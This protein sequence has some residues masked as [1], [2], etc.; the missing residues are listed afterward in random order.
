MPIGRQ[1]LPHDLP[2]GIPADE[3]LFFITICSAHRGSHELLESG[4]PAVLLG[5]VRHRQETGLW[6]ARIF[7]VMP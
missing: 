3:A 6:F 5:A 4:R 1:K 7:L 2:P